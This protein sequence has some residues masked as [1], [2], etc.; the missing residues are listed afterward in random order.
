MKRVT[1]YNYSLVVESRGSCYQWARNGFSD[2]RSQADTE[3]LRMIRDIVD[4]HHHRYGSSRVCEELRTTYGGKRVSLK[5]VA[6]L[7]HENG[8]NARRRRL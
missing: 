8:L 4:K 6:R 7:M 2:R 1:E 5:K 3:L